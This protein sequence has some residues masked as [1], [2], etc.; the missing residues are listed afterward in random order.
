MIRRSLPWLLLVLVLVALGL[1]NRNNDAPAY[2]PRLVER[3]FFA[4]GTL[5]SISVYLQDASQAAAAEAAINEA[6]L[7]L[8]RFERRHRPWGEGELADLNRALLRGEQAVIPGELRPLFE[9]SVELSKASGGL[10]EPRIGA[11]VK[12]WGFDEETHLRS[13]P[14]PA[15][16]IVGLM[17]KLRA[18]PA[19]LSACNPHPACYGAAA[20]VQWDFGAIAKGLAA[21][22]LVGQLAAA[23]FANTIV[24]AGGNLVFSGQRGERSWRI[25]IRHPR[26]PGART[27]ATFAPREPP[28]AALAVV[29]SGDYE[30]YFE[31]E[32]RRYHHILDP[33][34]GAP[35][36]GLISATVFAHDGALADAAATALIVAGPAHWRDTARRMGVDQALVVDES[37]AV[38]VTPALAARAG[39]ADAEL[40]FAEGLRWSVAP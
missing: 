12:L 5:V 10:F 37:G 8:E 2:D 26:A 27:L 30:R 6:Q 24:N 3:E 22:E 15:D 17:Q 33:R 11:L 39:D 36:R 29:T 4:L 7:W 16:D 20:G 13:T 18:A 21:Q 40:R 32:G 25:G 9:R 23:G 35:A 31:H 1:R 19:T 14:P 38:Q 28:Q 34:T